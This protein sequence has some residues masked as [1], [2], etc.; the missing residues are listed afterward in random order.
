MSE[1]AEQ[2]KVKSSNKGDIGKSY[3]AQI[4]A[5]DMSDEWSKNAVKHAKDAFALTIASGN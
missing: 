5:E 3:P 2:Q 1:P 4:F